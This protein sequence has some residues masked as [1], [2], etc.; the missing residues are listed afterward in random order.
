MK[1]PDKILNQ[2]YTTNFNTR[3]LLPIL[4]SNSIDKEFIGQYGTYDEEHLYFQLRDSVSINRV[5]YDNPKL[6]DDF[7]EKNLKKTYKV[8]LYKL[9]NIILRFSV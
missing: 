3:N 5:G 9:Q 7:Y 4:K 6:P 8:S 2:I 1:S